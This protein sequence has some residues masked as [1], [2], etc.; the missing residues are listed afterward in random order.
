M[1]IP[2]I[3]DC[4]PGHDDAIALVLA[5]ASPELEILAVTTSAGNQT[6]EKTT[7]NAR[8]VLSFIGCDAPVARGA[9]KPLFRE[10]I[11]AALARRAEHTSPMVILDS[12][13]SGALMVP[14]G[15]DAGS[16]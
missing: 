2:V 14:T 9:S 12:D 8:K 3:M 13:P 7:L 1:P 5:H 11:G 6:I 4:D 15:A 10:L 16:V